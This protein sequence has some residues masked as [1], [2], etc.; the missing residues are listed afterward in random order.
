M[1]ACY[2]YVYQDEDNTLWAS[3]GFAKAALPTLV[4]VDPSTGAEAVV[5]DDSPFHGGI[6][7]GLSAGGARLFITGTKQ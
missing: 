5:Y 2:R 4:E 3:V 6:Q 1:H 7:L